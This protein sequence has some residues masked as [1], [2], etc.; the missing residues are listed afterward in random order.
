MPTN[1]F[2]FINKDR[3]S[4]SLSNNR[5]EQALAPSNINKHVQRL[6]A[7]QRRKQSL[8]LG[9]NVPA[10]VGW[11]NLVRVTSSDSDKAGTI[12]K[13]E[14]V[15]NDDDSLPDQEREAALRGSSSL[16]SESPASTIDSLPAT[17]I[18]LTTSEHGILQ[19]FLREWMPSAKHSPIGCQIAGF[20]PVWPKDEKISAEVI[21]GA[22]QSRDDLSV[23]SLL[24]AGARR[25]HAIQSSRARGLELPELYAWH[26]VRALR[27]RLADPQ[28]LDERFVLDLSYLMLADLH[29][30]PPTRTEVYWRIARDLI[31]KLGGF[32]ALQHFTAL[33]VIAYDYI[34]SIDTITA[35]LLDAFRDVALLGID[36]NA[37]P[38]EIQSQ[39]Q[40]K[41]RDMEPRLRHAVQ[42]QNIMYRLF[43]QIEL[44]PPTIVRTFKAYVAINVERMYPVVAGPFRRI[45]GEPVPEKSRESP[46]LT[47]AD[48]L[49]IQTRAL[50]SHAWL[51]Y[52]AMGFCGYHRACMDVDDP[53][54]EA[55]IHHTPPPHVKR[56]SRAWQQIDMVRELLIGTGWEIKND[57]L[58]WMYAAGYL[59]ATTPKD[60]DCNRTRMLIHAWSMGV[61]DDDTLQ[62]LMALHM[63]FDKIAPD[64]KV[65]LG[66]VLRPFDDD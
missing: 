49:C 47:A 12:V 11:Q 56:V 42:V 32:L 26:A 18:K 3:S 60:R 58:L 50:M 53:W 9:S 7:R 40:T 13:A 62:G 45:D 34:I 36:P 23:Y 33:I 35:P 24:A 19:Y 54:Q 63:P 1:E 17:P 37:G 61:R 8:V 29:N 52:T 2:L 57:R 55:H 43:C 27:K 39:L 41:L 25:M 59:L 66:K 38:A 65:M 51:W 14:S 46:G 21:T 31:I 48:E 44:L 20:T 4:K 28:S 6:T 16:S 64:W 10:V 15:S 30:D 22:L 5:S